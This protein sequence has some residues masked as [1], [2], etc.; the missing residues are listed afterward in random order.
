MPPITI[1]TV[2]KLVVWSLVVG[3]VL[4][5]LNI[6]PL[7]IFG[8]LRDGVRGLVDNLEYYSSRALTYVLLGAVV[9]VPVW[10]FFYLW[11]AMKGRG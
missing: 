11:R 5:F 1:A 3:A 7:D 8:W 6:D 10:A 4:A 2:V 9:V